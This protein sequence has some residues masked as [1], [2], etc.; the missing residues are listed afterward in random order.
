MTEESKERINSEHEAKNLVQN[1]RDFLVNNP[2]SM[3]TDHDPV[4]ATWTLS[5]RFPF[6][7]RADK[8]SNE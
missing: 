5:F 3:S 1:W 6:R 8:D 7:D 4:R 2:R